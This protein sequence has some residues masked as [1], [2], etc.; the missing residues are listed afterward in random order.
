M[1]AAG[2]KAAA[3]R[4]RVEQGGPATDAVARDEEPSGRGLDALMAAAGAK[5]AALDDARKRG[6]EMA[7][8][9]PSL[10][11]AG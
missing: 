3:M 6:G 11:A 8:Q 2:T 1:A 5:A 10:V 4:G 7:A 9:A